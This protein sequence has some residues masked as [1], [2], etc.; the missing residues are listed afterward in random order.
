MKNLDIFSLTDN[1][2]IKPLNSVD[3]PFIRQLYALAVNSAKSNKMLSI[4]MNS[5]LSSR[6]VV[7]NNSILNIC[8]LTPL[9]DKDNCKTLVEEIAKYRWKSLNFNYDDNYWKECTNLLFLDYILSSCLCYV[10]IYDSASGKSS[11]NVEKFYATR[12][13]FIAGNVAGIDASETSKYTNY[14]S[15]ILA[16]YKM[17]SLRVLKLSHLKKGF[18]I[19]Q[20][21]SAINFH[22]T[23]KVTPLFLISAF[24]MGIIP[25][26]KENIVK[27]KYIKDNGQEREIYTTLSKD[28]FS[29][30]YGNE[31]ANTVVNQCEMKMDR[32]YIRIPELG[33]S[34]YDN[35]GMR[36]LNLSRI[37][38]IEVVD[39]FDTQY[40]DID[41]STIIPFFKGTIE[42]IN[43]I[44]VLQLIYQT[45]LNTPASEDKS[46][47]ELRA[48]L[49]S[50]V[51]SRFTIGTTTFQK[52]LHNYMMQ[53]KS[54]FKGYTGKPTTY[55]EEKLDTFNL[56]FE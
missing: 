5:F 25:T 23:V 1:K 27:F 11:S 29:K 44:S 15:P 48:N 32:G 50:Y 39:T 4:V 53:Y 35:S 3:N 20:P 47:G 31:Y 46:I 33:C 28:I 51:D 13:R 30:Y 2:Y 45:L 18:K 56:G 12:N 42:A 22:R 26:L 19:T 10:E 7:E 38:S 49:I 17:E 40:I 34:K 54:V 16:D 14:L 21:R 24:I 37:T 6:S 8:Q 55:T 9:I 43:D 36:A 41:F 52:E